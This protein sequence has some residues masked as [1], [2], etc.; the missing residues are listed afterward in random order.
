MRLQTT[1]AYK[2]GIQCPQDTA[3][4][5]G[6]DPTDPDVWGL[7]KLD[8][9]TCLIIGPGG[10]GEITFLQSLCPSANISV[11]SAHTDE[12]KT[13]I[14]LDP[15]VLMHVGDI[16]DMPFYSGA[17]DYVM[18]FNVL[19]HCFSPY[20]AI[21]EVRRV[22]KDDGSACFLLPSFHGP[23]GGKGPFHLHCLTE[24]VWGQLL[25]K[26]GLDAV[27]TKVIHGDVDF[28]STYMQFRCVCVPLPSPHDQILQ[29]I[30]Q[31][32]G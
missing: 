11:L 31:L 24:E 17:F 2:G 4:M 28:D 23:E 27:A 1:Y 26:V 18:A 19:E 3:P 6:L 20:M 32:K 30:K 16:H 7:K 13:M 14:D 5:Y 29:D 15:M 25:V 12:F 10:K 22:L 21:M 9:P 8:A